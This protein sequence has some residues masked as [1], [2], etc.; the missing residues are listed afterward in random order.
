MEN[1]IAIE[2]EYLTKEWEIPGW[3]DKDDE[4]E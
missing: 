1:V 3:D 2:E 4:E